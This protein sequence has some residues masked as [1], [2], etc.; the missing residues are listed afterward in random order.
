MYAVCAVRYD[1]RQS[2]CRFC[3]MTS[4]QS[5]DYH[6]LLHFG[7]LPSHFSQLSNGSSASFLLPLKQKLFPLCLVSST[8]I[9][10]MSGL[11]YR[12][13]GKKMTAQATLLPSNCLCC[14]HMLA[15]E[16][17]ICYCISRTVQ[18][19]ETSVGKGERE[20]AGR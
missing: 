11:D 9:A 8:R 3:G 17:G 4:T 16:T 5:Y 2:S 14:W 6:N 20:A 13:L 7:L 1:I 10:I 19:E 12:S 15:C 18:H